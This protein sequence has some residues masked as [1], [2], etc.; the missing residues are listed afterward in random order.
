MEMKKLIE[1]RLRVYCKEHSANFYELK[2]YFLMNTDLIHP[3]IESD[4][5]EAYLRLVHNYLTTQGY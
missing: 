5:D 1:D 3:S 4:K 2:N